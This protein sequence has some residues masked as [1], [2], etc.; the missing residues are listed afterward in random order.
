MGS[1]AWVAW[2]RRDH[3]WEPEEV[4]TGSTCFLHRD[5]HFLT[6]K[7]DLH[8]K[9]SIIIGIL[10]KN[11]EHMM[12]ISYE[13]YVQY[14]LSNQTDRESLLFREALLIPTAGAP[15]KHCKVFRDDI[16]GGARYVSWKQTVKCSF[17]FLPRLSGL[18][19]AIGNMAGTITG[20]PSLRLCIL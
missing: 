16:G 3:T 9:F 10:V 20:T 14:A 17:L 1:G 4:P 13:S 15:A 19:F 5:L 7:W 11:G 18:K 12:S 6:H 2:A 8:T